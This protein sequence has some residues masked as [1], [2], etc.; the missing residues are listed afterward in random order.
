M[1]TVDNY[2]S[3]LEAAC[4]FAARGA[5]VALSY[6]GRDPEAK[7]KRDGTWV[8]EADWAAEEEIRR[9][10]ASS[11]PQHNVLGE[12]HGLK[13]A[14]GGSPV[15]GAPTW[16]IDP[17]DGTTNFM[18]GIP[19]WATLVALQAEGMSVVGVV[20]ARALGEVYDAGVG[21]RARMNGEEIRIDPA[22][23]IEDATVVYASAE[24]FHHH[25]LAVFFQELTR[26]CSRSRGFGDFWGHVLVA[27]G[28][29]HVMIEPELSVWDVA[30]LQPIVS[31]AGGRL[32]TLS[33]K[34]WTNSGSC[35]TTNGTLHD[36][37][38]ALVKSCRPVRGTPVP[39][40]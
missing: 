17:I 34:P 14:G 19:I 7:I 5:R 31:E 29:V 24:D 39:D 37:I 18:A 11:F 20:D 10:I 2:S 25:G 27:R 12:E 3:E 15:E 30:P 38:L 21:L 23:R 28:S 1:P 13:A 32:T 26:R 36:D 8:T 33:G 16:I 6:Y 40:G 22:T 9:S 35:L 4:E